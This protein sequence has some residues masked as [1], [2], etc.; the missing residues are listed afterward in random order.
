MLWPMV[1]VSRPFHRKNGRQQ[2]PHTA[3]PNSMPWPLHDNLGCKVGQK[4]R[5]QL[6][7]L[8]LQQ[9]EVEHKPD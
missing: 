3:D 7:F 9:E 5:Q 4:V 2:T 1:H 6:L 8:Y